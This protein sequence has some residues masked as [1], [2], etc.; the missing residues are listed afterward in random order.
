MVLF[1]RLLIK[2]KNLTLYILRKHVVMFKLSVEPTQKL[3]SLI[4]M[5]RIIR[6]TDRKTCIFS[7][8]EEILIV[9]SEG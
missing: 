2:V 1:F 5:L 4:N 7:K 6:Q 8:A 9:C 3:P